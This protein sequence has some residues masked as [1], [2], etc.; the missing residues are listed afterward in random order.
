MLLFTGIG[1]PGI[2]YAGTRHNIGFMVLDF[3]AE[4]RGL[5]W[6]E[7]FSGLYTEDVIGSEKV[8]LLKPMTFMNLSGESVA[9]FMR[10]Y[11]IE[12][13]NF[14]LVHDEL[15]FPFEK[16]KLL[17]G[18]SSAGHNG[19]SSV[20]AYLDNQNYH[21]LR[22]GIAGIERAKMRGYSAEYVLANFTDEERK[23][24]PAFIKKG[25]EALLYA[26]ENGIMKAMNVFNRK[27]A[28][29]TPE[30]TEEL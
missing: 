5:K 18:G 13:E 20:T 21:R 16:M 1:N 29:E 2:K 26:A 28:E 23:A 10:Y 17:R 7:G 15:D 14:I 4:T 22:M 12:P 8:F 6:K 19:V 11:K 24:L 9:P 3:L 27:P 25:T 30:K